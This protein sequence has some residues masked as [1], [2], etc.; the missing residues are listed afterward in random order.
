M[1]QTKKHGFRPLH[2]A[3]MIA[4]FGMMMLIVCISLTRTKNYNDNTKKNYSDITL[5]W[6]LSPDSNEEIDF[7]NL[8]QYCDDDATSFFLYYRLPK[9]DRDTTLIYRSKDV[10]TSIYV[11][12]TRIYETSVPDSRF[13]NKSPGNLWNEVFIDRSYSEQILK[14]QADLVYDSKSLVVDNFF[15]GDASNIIVNFVHDRLFAIFV[16]ILMTLIGVIL[17]ILN[18]I[19]QNRSVYMGHGLFYLGIYSFLIGMWCLLETNV[20]Q[21]FSSDQRILQLCNNIIMITAMLPLFLY[22]DYT[23]EVFQNKFTKI[24]CCIDIIYIYICVI[25][26]FTGLSNMHNLL[27]GSQLGLIIGSLM[28]FGWMLYE[29]YL[30]HKKKDNLMPILLQLLGIGSLTFSMFFQYSKFM[31]GDYADRAG[32]LRVGSLFFVLFFSASTHIQ[33]N[34]LIAKGMKYNVVKALAYSD[35]L[36]NAG[37]RTAYLEKIESYSHSNVAALGIV[38]LDINNLKYVNDNLGH[39]LGDE[40]IKQ[41][42]TIIDESFGKYGKS[43]RI[44]GDEFCVLIEHPELGAIYNKAYETFSKLIEE[45]NAGNPLP[46]KIQIA[47][48]FS[49]CTEMTKEKIQEAIDTADHL[50][51]ENKAMLKSKN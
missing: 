11:N 6:H 22:L 24:L 37:N 12:G 10:Y 42:S 46:V 45:A 48:G 14:L 9:L 33:T 38:Y 30:A 44:G 7:R 34:K 27:I 16:S 47:H 5:S 32:M 1:G 15:L 2:V 4:F 13:Y 41:A 18:F 29:C 39:E 19:S 17:I 21:F 20:L 36:T 51:Y 3:Y 25:A 26:Q 50:M 40:L 49:V 31:N 43:Y 35:G 28:F 23:Y 8:S